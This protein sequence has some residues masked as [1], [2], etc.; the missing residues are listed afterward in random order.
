MLGN[1]GITAYPAASINNVKVPGNLK[2]QI[3]NNI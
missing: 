2:V 3:I 1:G